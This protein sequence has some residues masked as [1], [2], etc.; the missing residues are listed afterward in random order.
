MTT[1]LCL[2]FTLASDATFGR[3]DGVAGLL[4]EEIEYDE[5]TGLP[6]V[7]GRVLKGLLVN[8]CAALLFA[9]ERQGCPAMNALYGAA[10]RLFG[11]P[12]STLQD[13]G[14]LRV[15]NAQLPDQLRQA[16]S[17]DV[18]AG[19]FAPV[20]V[21]ESLTTIR[22]QTALNAN[23]APQ[24]GSLRTMRALIRELT[25]IA[26]LSFDG[27]MSQNE[28][29]LLVACALALRRAGSGRNRGRGRLKDIC[30]LKDGKDIAG[31]AL[32]HFKTLIKPEAA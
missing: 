4:D 18:A 24:K 1:R 3:G 29:G 5:V 23:G 12:G 25:L 13:D 11:N 10:R 28:S 16:V 22:R 30:L 19:T 31:E 32:D 6:F 21:L 9:L 8:E 26:D 20:E 17:E 2:Q 15:G 14:L 27:E 7:R